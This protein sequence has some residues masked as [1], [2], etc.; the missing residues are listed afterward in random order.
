[1]RT[2]HRIAWELIYGE[3]PTK[4]W[5][6]HRCDN[7]SCVN[8]DHL[9]LGTRSDNFKDFVARKRSPF[10]KKTHCPRGHPYAGENLRVVNYKGYLRRACKE[11]QRLATLRCRK[12]REKMQTRLAENSKFLGSEK[13]QR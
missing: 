9:Y 12:R 8:P 4:M 2:T 10:L 3:I 11:C 13:A 7:P 1:M 6:L 5:V